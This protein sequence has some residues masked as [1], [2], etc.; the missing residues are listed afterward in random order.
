ML[1]EYAEKLLIS[2][3][4]LFGY[5]FRESISVWVKEGLEF[6]KLELRVRH[7][8]SDDLSFLCKR[9]DIYIHFCNHHFYA[10]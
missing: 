6:L 3:I 2:G 8:L 5:V 1:V 4:K 10:Q 7:A 9:E